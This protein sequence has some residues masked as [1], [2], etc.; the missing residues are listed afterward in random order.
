MTDDIDLVRY[1]MYQ[2]VAKVNDKQALRN[3]LLELLDKNEYDHY[4]LPHHALVMD[5]CL[6]Y[7]ELHYHIS[8]YLELPD[9]PAE[10]LISAWA[11]KI[12]EDSTNTD[13]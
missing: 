3:I 8:R 2:D 13:K 1:R 7:W 11:P 12:D 6:R 10:S 9:P 5:H 4:V